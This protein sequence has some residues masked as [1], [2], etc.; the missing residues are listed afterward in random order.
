[1]YSALLVCWLFVVFVQGIGVRS[2]Q[3]KED[4]ESND[5]L[6]LVHSSGC[7]PCKKVKEWFNG[8][9]ADEMKEKGI[10]CR[11]YA[12]NENPIASLK[13]PAIYGFPTFIFHKR[14]SG[15]IVADPT[16]KDGILNWVQNEANH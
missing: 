15:W 11:M 7:E 4:F 3:E 9:F 6:V 5:F 12:P 10:E 8:N 13:I 1:M 16:D 14:G 2:L